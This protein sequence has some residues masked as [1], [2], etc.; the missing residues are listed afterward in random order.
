M[1]TIEDFIKKY[2]GKYVEVAGSANAKNQ[3]VD[4]VNQYFI[5]VWNV[6]IIEWTNAV[7][8]PEKISKPL[9]F[10]DKTPEYVPEPGEVVV[11][12]KYGSLYGS[13]GHIGIVASATQKEMYVFEENYPTGSPCTINRHTYLGCRGFI[14][15]Q[16]EDDI[17]CQEELEKCKTEQI[18]NDERIKSARK[19]RDE[20]KRRV[21]ELESEKRSVETKFGL[22]KKAWSEKEKVLQDLVADWKKE[23]QKLKN[24]TGYQLIFEGIKKLF[25]GNK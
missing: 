24:K 15:K 16:K 19:E 22:E 5:D 10:V 11:F 2:D 4:L 17:S 6:P 23:C 14:K 1:P 3:C 12:K 13:A 18:K 8:F 21:E 9:Y 20:Y 25:K 7:D